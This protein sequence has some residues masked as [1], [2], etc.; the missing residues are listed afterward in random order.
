M[1]EKSD[2]IN[3]NDL[4]FIIVKK[5]KFIVLITIIFVTAGGIYT[6]IKPIVYIASADISPNAL[7][8]Y[9]GSLFNGVDNKDS[10]LSILRS[11]EFITYFI[12]NN[13]ANLEKVTNEK[14]NKKIVAELKRKIVNFGFEKNLVYIKI[15]TKDK[16]I[17]QELL[18]S[19]IKCF[20]D[21]VKELAIKNI[22]DN[23]LYLNKKIDNTSNIEMKKVFYQLIGE[24]ERRR[25]ITVSGINKTFEVIK[26][27]D[28]NNIVKKP[29]A[30]YNYII[31]L[32]FGLIFGFAI[33][34]IINETDKSEK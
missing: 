8:N 12:N 5:W 2:E 32:I 27:T 15:T 1:K 10:A 34:L 25:M 30:K 13:L 19:Y 17:S 23:I 31:S 11:K 24:Q 21:L 6:E 3:I 20:Y 4:I 29:D 14:N 26:I 9:Y 18:N 33:V 22:D 7:N 16:V 28:L